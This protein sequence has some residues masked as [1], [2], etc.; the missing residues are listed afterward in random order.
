M[1]KRAY[2]EEFEMLKGTLQQWEVCPV[3]KSLGGGYIIKGWLNGRS[4]QTS[5][6]Q[7]VLPYCAVRTE[8]GSL[9]G[10]GKVKD[11][12]RQQGLL[13]DDP[14]MFERIWRVVQKARRAH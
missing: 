5:R 7:D 12:G 9:Y 8:T 6:I 11:S 10:L 2:A 1:G 4:V 14:L 13:H 3:K